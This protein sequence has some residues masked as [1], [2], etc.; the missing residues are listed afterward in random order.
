[1]EKEDVVRYIGIKVK[2]ILKGTGDIYNGE[3]L[4]CGNTSFSF[5]DKF[6]NKLTLDY[7]MCGLIRETGRDQ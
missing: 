3:I 6:N 5:V 4:E 7:D 1:M 2:I